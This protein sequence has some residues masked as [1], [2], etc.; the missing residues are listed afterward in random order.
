M[1]KVSLN[2]PGCGKHHATYKEYFACWTSH[3][4]SEAK[5]GATP[6]DHNDAIKYYKLNPTEIENGLRILA[7]EIGIFR[8]RIDLIG[9]DKNQNLVIIDVTAGYDWQR[10]SLQLQRYKRNI[11]WMARKIFGLQD[12]PPMRLLVVRPGH[13]V[14]DVTQG[15]T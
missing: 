6:V 3:L 8:G 15:I 2:C 10:K 7:S 14:K 11:E 1:E 4:P 12:P 13:Y 9:V 5:G